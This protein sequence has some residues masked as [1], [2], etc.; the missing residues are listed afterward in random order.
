MMINRYFALIPV[1]FLAAFFI[2]CDNSDANNQS[3]SSDFEITENV[4]VDNSENNSGGDSETA[5]KATPPGV[6]SSGYGSAENYICADQTARQ[7]DYGCEDA[8]DGKRVYIY[9]PDKLRN[10]TSA[11]VI[12]YLHGFVAVS[13]LLYMNHIRHLTKQGYIVIFP[14]FNREYLGM[15]A[16]MDQGVMLLHALESANAAMEYL[17]PKAD[18][19]DVTL[20]GHSLG[21]LLALS[22]VDGQDGVQ[23]PAPKAIVVA[24]AQLDPTDDSIEG[25]P[26]FVQPLIAGMLNLIDWQT[27]LKAVR[28]PVIVLV[29]NEDTIASPAM[30]V[31]IFDA[32]ENAPSKVV[33]CAE[34]DRHGA[35]ALIADHMGPLCM[36]GVLPDG[37]YDATGSFF[38]LDAMDYHFFWAALDAAIDGAV[39]VDFDMGAWSDATP[40]TPVVT[41]A[42]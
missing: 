1:V 34:T 38:R 6:P 30:A 14:Q 27:K 26:E 22:W 19:G 7:L 15:L 23:G 37:L 4:I 18:S 36:E 10:G 21:G 3:A 42:Q 8:T 13:P 20:F 41:L 35:P 25:I 40:V 5:R 16:D 11:P 31:N 12:V 29:G 2:S 24:E 32:L 39:I 33:Y 17:G 28:C 9:T